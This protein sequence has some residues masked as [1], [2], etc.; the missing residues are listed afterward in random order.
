MNT[1]NHSNFII[2][3]CG[4]KDPDLAASA[5]E[6]GAKMVGLMMYHKSK[7]YVEPEQ[8]AIIA[9]SVKAKGGIPVA[10]FVDADADAMLTLC[11]LTGIET[12]QLHGDISRS[13]HIKL[14][15]NIRR[16][17]TMHVSKYGQVLP[18]LTKSLSCLNSERDLLLFDSEKGGSGISFNWNNFKSPY[19][20]PF[21]LAGGLNSG[22]VIEAISKIRPYGIDVS[23]GVEN[24]MGNKDI[25]LIRQFIAAT[26]GGQ[27]AKF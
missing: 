18:E 19:C 24:A 9:K 10:I 17:Y 13:E 27:N 15:E 6:A 2:K 20:M 12:V 25:Q 5:V 14:P 26:K 1:Q 22:N 21:I 16:I 11:H 4:I 3:I 23:S 7:R 8:A